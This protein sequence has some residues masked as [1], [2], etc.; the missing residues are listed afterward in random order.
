M[1]QHGYEFR[2]EIKPFKFPAIS[3]TVLAEISLNDKYNCSN[4]MH[5]DIT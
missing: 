1:I 4:C 2:A 5:F 3:I